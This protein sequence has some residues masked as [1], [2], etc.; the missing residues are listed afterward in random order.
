MRDELAPG[1][2]LGIGELPFSGV[3]LDYT[4]FDTKMLYRDLGFRQE[5]PFRR[6]VRM[7]ADRIAGKEAQA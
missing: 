1:F 2:P 5:V 4:E 6:G 3:S 7:T